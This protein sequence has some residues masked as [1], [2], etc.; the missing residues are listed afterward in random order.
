[1]TLNSVLRD[2]DSV[3]GWSWRT[4]PSKRGMI[5]ALLSCGL[6]SR[7]WTNAFYDQG[8]ITQCFLLAQRGRTLE[9]S[10]MLCQFRRILVVHAGLSPEVACM[11]S[12]H[13]MKATLLSWDAE[14]DID[15][16]LRSA[17]GH[18]RFAGASSCVKLLSIVQMH[19]IPQVQPEA[20]TWRRPSSRTC[21]TWRRK[22]SSGYLT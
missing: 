20:T 13:S 14:L 4:K 15:S 3:R 10:R 8:G 12:L 16:V 2:S 1:M 5:W 7:S 18:H 19:R 21:L 22:D 11:F 17:Q 9:Y 6:S